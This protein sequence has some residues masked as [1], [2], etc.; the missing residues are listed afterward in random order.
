MFWFLKTV[1][2]SQQI[3]KIGNNGSNF[4]FVIVLLYIIKID[5]NVLSTF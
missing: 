1:G 2:K 3:I 4:K 5:C